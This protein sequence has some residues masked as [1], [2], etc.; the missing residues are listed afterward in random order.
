M[1]PAPVRGRA[2]ENAKN[3]FLGLH[4]T[5][6]A[7]ETRKNLTFL[8]QASQFQ[9]SKTLKT[10]GDFLASMQFHSEPDAFLGGG[11]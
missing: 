10:E 1:V 11:G 8:L 4:W 9:V 2:V 6:G 5:H 3:T 7:R